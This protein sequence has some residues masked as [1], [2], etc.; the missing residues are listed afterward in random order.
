VVRALIDNLVARGLDPTQPRLFISDGSKALSKAIRRTFGRHTPVQRGQ[1]Q[2]ADVGIKSIK[3]ATL[4]A[5]WRRRALRRAWETDDAEQSEKLIRN[6]ARRLERDAPQWL[7]A[8]QLQQYWNEERL[9]QVEGLQT[10]SKAP[11]RKGMMSDE[12]HVSRARS[13]GGIR[14]KPARGELR[15][16]LPMEAPSLAP[17]LPAPLEPPAPA[18]A[19]TLRASSNPR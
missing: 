19:F 9:P 8:G 16:S 1:I 2:H 7:C 10:T 18:S 13:L 14:N 11:G 12:S 5:G 4:W 17:L 6:L 15:R 3:L